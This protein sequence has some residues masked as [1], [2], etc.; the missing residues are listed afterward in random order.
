V[1]VVLC[2]TEPCTVH[3]NVFPTAIASRIQRPY[4]NLTLVNL[5]HLSMWLRETRVC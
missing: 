1:Y 3:I 5:N 4:V 2:G